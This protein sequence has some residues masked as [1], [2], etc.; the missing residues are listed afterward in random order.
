[1]LCLL[2]HVYCTPCIHTCTRAQSLTQSSHEGW[3]VKESGTALFGKTR[4]EEKMVQTH[5]D[6]EGHTA[7]VL[8]VSYKSVFAYYISYYTLL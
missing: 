1:M 4:L 2:S 5:T 3:C 7:P 6:Q 8:P